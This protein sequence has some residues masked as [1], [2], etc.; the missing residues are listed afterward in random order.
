MPTISVIVPV[1][2]VEKY[3][4]RCVDSI[5]TQ[6]FTDFELIL[7]DDGSPDNCGAICDEYAKKD[8]RVVVIHQEN[9]G[10]SAARNAGIDWAFANSNSEW[11]TFVDSDDW[12]HPKM[13]EELFSRVQIY[14]ADLAL[15]G[16]KTVYDE[17]FVGIRYPSDCKMSNACLTKEDAVHMLEGQAWYHVVTW[18]KLYRRDIFSQLRFP[19]GYIHEDAAIVHRVLGQCNRIV[20]T[21]IPLYFYFQRNSSIMGDRVSIKQTDN[22]SALADRICYSAQMGWHELKNKAIGRYV[23]EFFDMYFR[24]QRT[25]DNEK[26]FLRM[27]ASLK[28]ALPHIL[29]CDSVSKAH[30]LYLTLIRINPKFYIWLRSLRK[31]E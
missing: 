21:D 11:L 30:K 27:E 6:T 23:P 8:S 13:L 22:L 2:K 9:G 5:L 16:V 12:I 24:F 3:I 15:C 18:N 25:Q 17:E 28:N 10:L 14:K 31:V 20:L 19:E 29:R 1:Y 26:Y 4:H 7:V